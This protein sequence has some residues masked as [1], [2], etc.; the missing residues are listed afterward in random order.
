MADDIKKMSAELARDPGSLVFLRLGE[1]LRRRGE[2]AA[3]VQVVLGGLERHPDLVD[4]H[5]LYARV[6][7]GQEEFERAR[8]V[9]NGVLER[10]PRYLGALKG[11]GFLYFRMGD[12]DAALDHL[13]LALSVD[14]TDPAVVRALHSV[15]SAVEEAEL[16]QAKSEESVFA[17]LE[18]AEHG[19]LLVDH[20]G[21]VLG[22][23]LRDANQADVSDAVA[24]YLAG[25]AQEAERTARLLGLGDWRWIVVEGP[26]GNVYVTLPTPET[27]LF[28][29]RDRSVPSGRLAMLA[30]RAVQIA[31]QWL[32]RQQL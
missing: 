8:D 16:Q 31:R 28:I 22:G 20:R 5:D 17:G 9:W 12:L 18:G 10:A 15:R 24:A 30:G 26:S 29:L 25:A 14:P 23:A 2:A 7:V 32:E 1:A 19:M 3:A 21:R 27:L 11:L 13:E 4:G 6:L